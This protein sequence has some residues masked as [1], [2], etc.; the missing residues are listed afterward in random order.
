MTL[1]SEC[2]GTYANRPSNK[3]A[4]LATKRHLKATQGWWPGRV[5]R[6]FDKKGKTDKCYI[7]STVKTL[8]A[9]WSMHL[10]NKKL[11]EAGKTHR[12]LSYALIDECEEP[13]IE[14]LEELEV[15]EDRQLER[16]EQYFIDLYGATAVNAQRAHGG[17]DM[18]TS[19]PGYHV[20]YRRAH[21][22]EKAT[23][24]AAYYQS[25]REEIAARRN[26]K[27]TCGCGGRY[28]P[29]NRSHHLRTAK[30]Q[31]WLARQN[32]SPQNI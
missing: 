26:T 24:D 4:H 9:R 1:C 15:T 13:V 12:C 20:A 31:K 19:D 29:R 27:N 25:H 18:A 7:G 11:F 32:P 10:S 28:T 3:Q 2:Q 14:L 8:K 21:R 22:D 5:Y 16:R 23:Y 6:I 17:V 30:H